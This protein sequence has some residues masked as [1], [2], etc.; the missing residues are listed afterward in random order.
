MILQIRRVGEQVNGFEYATLQAIAH[1]LIA[2]FGQTG[3]VT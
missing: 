2:E 3:T 1:R